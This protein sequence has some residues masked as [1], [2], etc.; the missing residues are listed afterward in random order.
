MTGVVV[1]LF[2][3]KG[4]GFVRDEQGYTRFI[5]ANDFTHRWEYDLLHEGKVV[6]FTPVETDKGLKGIE[7]TL[8]QA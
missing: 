6:Q 3:S 8:A 4:F 1:R 5:H 2:V 7:V